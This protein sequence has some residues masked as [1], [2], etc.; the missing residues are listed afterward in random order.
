MDGK[1][2]IFN[3][4]HQYLRYGESIL[5]TRGKSIW[6]LVCLPLTLTAL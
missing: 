6:T 5:L 1:N 2:T 4:N 3:R